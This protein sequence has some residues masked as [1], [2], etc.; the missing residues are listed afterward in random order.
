MFLKTKGKSEYI[1]ANTL[2]AFSHFTNALYN[3]IGETLHEGFKSMVLVCI[4]TD[5]LT[6]DSLGPLIGYKLDDIKYKNVFV[7]G[8]LENPVHAK[9]LDEVLRV[10][11]S[12]YNTPFIIAIDACLGSMDHVGYISVSEGPLK[13]GAGVNKE[14]TEVGDINIMGI[15]KLWRLY[16]FYSTAEYPIECCYENG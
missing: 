3:L 6:G 1:D 4:G 14:L 12:K 15:V 9:N 7:Y 16:G 10:I 11:K 2:A 8:T 13:P 5:R